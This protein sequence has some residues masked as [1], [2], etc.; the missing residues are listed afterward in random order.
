MTADEPKKKFKFQWWHKVIAFVVLPLLMLLVLWHSLRVRW[1]EP[2]NTEFLLN[3]QA[4]GRLLVEFSEESYYKKMLSIMSYSDSYILSSVSNEEFEDQMDDYDLSIY[5]EGEAC[6][7]SDNE[8]ITA[9]LNEKE[10]IFQK[11]LNLGVYQDPEAPRFEVDRGAIYI[12]DFMNE[13][14]F[15]MLLCAERDDADGVRRVFESVVTAMTA[16]EKG[17]VLIDHLISKAVLGSYILELLS[18]N[19]K[20]TTKIDL[21]ELLA[22]AYDYS[23]NHRPSAEELLLNEY[24]IAREAIRRSYGDDMNKLIDNDYLDSD[25]SWYFYLSA[26]WETQRNV[27]SYWQGVL[28][29]I[30]DLDLYMTGKGSLQGKMPFEDW[31]GDHGVLFM[32]DPVGWGVVNAIDVIFDPDNHSWKKQD[33]YAKFIYCYLLLKEI[34][35]AAP[36][37]IASIDKIQDKRFVQYFNEESFHFYYYSE[38]DWYLTIFDAAGRDL[39]KFYDWCYEVDDDG[40]CILHAVTPYKKLYQEPSAEEDE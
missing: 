17:G 14:R 7:V 8:K 13:L 36:L 25:Q 31:L 40:C 2:V 35:R 34:E 21:S 9:G 29:N 16:T 18:V 10:P 33:Q 3:Y 28:N 15:Y 24:V 26:E 22:K 30:D 5:E 38:N 11:F 23:V 19:Q 6:L 4:P 37:S 32:Q 39:K 12:F 1:V 27:A 20:L